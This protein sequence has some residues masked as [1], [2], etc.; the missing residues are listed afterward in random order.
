M[1]TFAAQKGEK[2]TQPFLA[3]VGSPTHPIDYFV[4][5]DNVAVPAGDTILEAFDR[6]FKTFYLHNVHYPIQVES[7]YNF[8]AT[9]LFEL[10]G[11]V[12]RPQVRALIASI[13]QQ[14]SVSA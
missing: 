14:M 9:V 7:F 4:I 10:P 5:C 1:D 6:L 11:V 3:C 12:P 8:V 13:T 2:F